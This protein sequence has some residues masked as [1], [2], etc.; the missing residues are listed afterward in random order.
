MRKTE[1]DTRNF[2]YEFSEFLQIFIILV[3]EPLF[4]IS[5]YAVYFEVP[6]NYFLY[7]FC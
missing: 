1:Y 5:I 6:K 3:I 2:L 7:L 4:V